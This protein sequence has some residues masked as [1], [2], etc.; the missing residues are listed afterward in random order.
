M[1]TKINGN[2]SEAGKFR[3]KQI[4]STGKHNGFFNTVYVS[5]Y[6]DGE[7]LDTRVKIQNDS[8]A[9]ITLC[10]IAGADIENFENEL[11]S[12]IEKYRI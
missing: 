10:F 11:N 6:I 2:L 8:G 3:I 9:E 1:K 12:L 5:D 7:K 4:I